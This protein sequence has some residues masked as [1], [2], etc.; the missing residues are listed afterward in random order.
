MLDVQELNYTEKYLMNTC[1]TT[2]DNYKTIFNYF[3]TEYK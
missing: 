2:Q 1:H 3:E